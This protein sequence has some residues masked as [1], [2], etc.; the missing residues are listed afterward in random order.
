MLGTT[1]VAETTTAAA[2]PLI[3]EAYNQSL[4]TKYSP[5]EID[6]IQKD[7][8]YIR[9][10][11]FAERIPNL[12]SKP[13]YIATAGGPGARKST[14]L[15]QVLAQ[16]A[17]FHNTVYLDPDQRGL[18]FMGNTYYNVSLNLYKVSLFEKYA[19]AQKSAY[20]YWRE[21]SIYITNTLMNEAFAKR[22]DIAHGTTL[23]SPLVDGF[24]AQLKAAGYEVVLLL[25][26]AEDELRVSA[27]NYRSKEQ[28]F[29]QTDP[30]DVV[31]KGI[32]FPQRMELYFKYADEMAIY[33]SE[34]IFAPMQ[35]AAKLNFAKHALEV[36][37]KPAYESFVAKYNKDAKAKTLA[38]PLPQ[39]S[40]ILSK[41]G[42]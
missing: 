15:E 38:Q 12:R 24:L 33:W 23:T 25:C 3:S 1:A 18:R 20:D 14:I 30:K 26:G 5:K 40:A 21:A 32:F 28:G 31:N 36:L 17:R 42:F 22:Y 16:D 8:R 6:L 10:L 4:L 19:D 39:W 37:D 2:V 34:K 29:Y 41:N 35:A 9:E 13:L 7:M 11:V 27:V